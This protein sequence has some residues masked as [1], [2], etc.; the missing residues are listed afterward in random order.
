LPFFVRGVRRKNM[1]P[2]IYPHQAGLGNRVGRHYS[3]FWPKSNHSPVVN[4]ILSH[5]KNRKIGIFQ[6]ESA[7]TG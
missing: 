1:M 4:Q 2:R 6:G 5:P 7:K 3:H